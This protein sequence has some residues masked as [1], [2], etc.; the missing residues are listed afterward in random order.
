MLTTRNIVLPPGEG[1]TKTPPSDCPASISSL[2]DLP[3]RKGG[4]TFITY[5]LAVINEDLEDIEHL[6]VCPRSSSSL[7][8]P[9][10]S[11]QPPIL[12][13][14]ALVS[15]EDTNDDGAGSNHQLGFPSLHTGS[16]G[17]GVDLY[18]QVNRS[19]L[20]D[21]LK[22]IGERPSAATAAATPE[23][24][25]QEGA[26]KEET[27]GQLSLDMPRRERWLG[28]TEATIA[29]TTWV[30]EKTICGDHVWVALESKEIDWQMVAWDQIPRKVS[31]H[32][33]EGGILV[34]DRTLRLDRYATVAPADTGD[35][36]LVEESRIIRSN[37]EPVP[38][39]HDWNEMARL[40]PVNSGSVPERMRER[41]LRKR[42][43]CHRRTIGVITQRIRNL[44]CK[45]CRKNGSQGSETFSGDD[46]H[47][48]ANLAWDRVG[49]KNEHLAGSSNGLMICR[50]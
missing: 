43:A 26:E 31:L 42:R 40:T 14:E 50:C 2:S 34:E 15:P 13:H 5:R 49:P 35:D 22:N 47:Q 41:A 18:R 37:T 4:N 21:M 39:F 8:V 23:E 29:P 24:A 9:G 27:S 17:S 10:D 28:A 36:H 11:Y 44:F 48:V 7:R 20:D 1:D 16:P 3:E 32:F 30:C 12:S 38:G 25:A 46:N 45:S 33:M 6:E 19:T